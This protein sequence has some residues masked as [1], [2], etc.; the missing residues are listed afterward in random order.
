MKITTTTT[1]TTT[2][3]IY[4]TVSHNEHKLQNRYRFVS[5]IFQERSS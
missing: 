1:T 4:Y 2:T 5:K 3:V